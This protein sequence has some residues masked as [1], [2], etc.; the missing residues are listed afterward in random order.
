MILFGTLPLARLWAA[1][2]SIIGCLFVPSCRFPLYIYNM[3]YPYSSPF[4]P[5]RESP[6]KTA[7]KTSVLRK[8]SSK[9]SKKV[10]AKFAVKEKVR[11]FAPAFGNGKKNLPE[12]LEAKRESPYLCIRFPKKKGGQ[13]QKEFYDKPYINDT[14][15]VQGPSPV[16][17]CILVK[18]REKP[19]ILE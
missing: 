13:N 14:E 17:I 5:V 19:S 4:H 8:S 11:T 12:N 9:T 16:C 7:L 15:T 1:L 18:F 6:C 2:P 3:V 10:L